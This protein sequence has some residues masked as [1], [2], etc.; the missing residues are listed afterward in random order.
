MW[1]FHVVSNNQAEIKM[2]IWEK[3]A[4]DRQ[5]KCDRLI[6]SLSKMS[7]DQIREKLDSMRRIAASLPS[8]KSFEAQQLRRNANDVENHFFLI[9]NPQFAFGENLEHANRKGFPIPQ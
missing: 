9:L 6:S 1:Y 8:W 3:A 4:A 2:N 5:S 7:A